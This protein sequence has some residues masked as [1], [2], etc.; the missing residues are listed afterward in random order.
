[1]LQRC[2]ITPYLAEWVLQGALMAI[3]MYG[4]G[5]RGPTREATL[6]NGKRVTRA[7]HSERL[8]TP[9]VETYA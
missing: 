1:M 5:L 2:S 7:R 6:G 3:Y 8:E 4:G 9:C